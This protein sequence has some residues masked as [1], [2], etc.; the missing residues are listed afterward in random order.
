VT[1][2]SPSQTRHSLLE[3]LRQSPDDPSAWDEFVARYGPQ[4]LSWC[5]RWRLQD[6]DAQDVTQAVLVKLAAKM[7]MFVYDPSRSFRGWLKTLARHALSDLLSDRQRAAGSAGA[8]GTLAEAEARTDLERRLEEAFDLELLQLATA[9]V[10]ERV[11]PHTWAAFELA[12]L[13]N[14]SGAEAAAKLGVSVAVVFKAKSKVQK[15]L[16][17]EI[18]RLERPAPS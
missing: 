12:A 17:D 8:V 18:A 10:R 13:D 5:Q 4:I 16:Q 1:D 9:R 11:E 7:R 6:A 3:R 14:L 2:P 15:M